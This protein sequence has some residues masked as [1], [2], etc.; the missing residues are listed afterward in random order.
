MIELFFNVAAVVEINDRVV[1][2]FA[3]DC[4]P[5]VSR[6]PHNSVLTNYL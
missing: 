3:K 4:Q 6:K 5:N 1:I 2:C